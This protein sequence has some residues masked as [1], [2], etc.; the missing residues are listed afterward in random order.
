MVATKIRVLFIE[1]QSLDASD[2]PPS[3]VLHT[4]LRSAIERAGITA[5]SDIR[6][7]KG[8]T[9]GVVQLG[10]SGKGGTSGG[11]KDGVMQQRY[12]SRE[13]R[14][15][16]VRTSLQNSRAVRTAIQSVRYAQHYPVRL[17][18]VRAF[19]NERVARRELRT[20]LEDARR[21]LDDPTAR[22][23]IDSV[24]ARIAELQKGT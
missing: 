24:L 9:S 4:E 17:T 3:A 6:K 10:S 23:N 21:R 18:V 11:G 2:A 8:G 19:G 22:K 7:R 1:V 5:N 20:R 16:A 14:I 12:Y 15:C 13:A